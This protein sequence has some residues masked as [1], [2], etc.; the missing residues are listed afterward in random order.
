MRFTIKQF[1]KE[2]RCKHE[3]VREK[4]HYGY[5]TKQCSKCYKFI[6]EPY[7]KKCDKYDGVCLQECDI[8]EEL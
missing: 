5:H 2:L 4:K 6:Q 3:W 8:K 7:H 1:I